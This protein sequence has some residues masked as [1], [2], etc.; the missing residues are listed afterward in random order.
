[1]KIDLTTRNFEMDARLKGYVNEKL[2]AIE[3]YLPRQVREV[4][5]VT[6]VLEDDPSGREDNRYVCEAVVTVPGAQLVSREG[7][8]NMFAAIDIVEAKL[9]SQVVKYKE[10]HTTE[11]RREKMAA[12]TGEMGLEDVLMDGE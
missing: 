11:P 9:K 1:M 12:K 4:A 8:V 10:K 6:A 2:S 7:T 3:K 5:V